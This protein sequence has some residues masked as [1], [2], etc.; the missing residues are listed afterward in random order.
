[1]D[2]RSRHPGGPTQ[3]SEEKEPSEQGPRYDIYRRESGDVVEIAEAE[4]D[5]RPNGSPCT[6]LTFAPINRHAA[7]HDHRGFDSQS[8]NTRAVVIA[9]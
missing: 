9:S 1:M 4:S 2:H 3:E 6:W 5:G 7:H 8:P